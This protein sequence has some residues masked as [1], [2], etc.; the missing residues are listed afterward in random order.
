MNLLDEYLSDIWEETK[1]PIEKIWDK[2][3]LTWIY[4]PNVHDWESLPPSHRAKIYAFQ[5]GEVNGKIYLSG[6]PIKCHLCGR[7]DQWAVECD[8]GRVRCFTCDHQPEDVGLDPTLV[9]CRVVSTVNPRYV[10]RFEIVSDPEFD[11]SEYD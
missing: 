8:G 11:G 1:P 7:D 5:D 10:S 2:W 3:R 6:Q 9:F 4:D